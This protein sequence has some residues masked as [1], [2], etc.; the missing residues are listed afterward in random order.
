MN[1]KALLLFIMSCSIVDI[2]DFDI[3]N[4]KFDKINP[5]YQARLEKEGKGVKQQYSIFAKYEDK[6]LCLCLNIDQFYGGQIRNKDKSGK[7]FCDINAPNIKFEIGLNPA[8]PECVKL[9]EVILAIEKKL[10]ENIEYLLSE[11]LKSKHKTFKNYMFCSSIKPFKVPSEDDSDVKVAIEDT[12]EHYSKFTL[13]YDEEYGSN[14]I[15]TIFEADDELEDGTYRKYDIKT[16]KDIEEKI[17]IWKKKVRILFKLVRV[18]VSKNPLSIF[19]GNKAYGIVFKLMRVH[20][21]N[22]MIEQKITTVEND[23][24]W[25]KGI[26]T[27]KPIEKEKKEKPEEIKDTKEEKQDKE[28]ED[29]DNNSGNDSDEEEIIEESLAVVPTD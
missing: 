28:N 29:D 9:K 22:S 5:A 8:L 3:R 26:K 1:F 14:N 20:I 17:S 18:W 25:M 19:Q 12:E 21:F 11:E 23:A 2:N 16:K 15:K 10:K 24:N 4:L 6:P 13:K 27:S 7:E